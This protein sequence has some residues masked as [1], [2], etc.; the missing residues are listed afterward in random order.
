MLTIT[1]AVSRGQ[2]S[3]FWKHTRNLLTVIY[4]REAVPRQRKLTVT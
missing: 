1:N 3:A 4:S 2:V